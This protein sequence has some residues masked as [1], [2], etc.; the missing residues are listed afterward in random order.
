MKKVEARIYLEDIASHLCEMNVPTEYMLVEGR[1]ED[2]IIRVAQSLDKG[3]LMLSSHGQSG[4]N[5]WK[6]GS[7]AQKIILRRHAS[8]MIVRAD[9]VCESDWGSWR[10]RRL[11]VPLDGSPRAECVLPLVAVL[12]RFHE[13]VVILAHV[14]SRPELPQGLLTTCEDLELANQL[15]EHRRREGIR[16]LQ[17]MRD[18]TPADVETRLIVSDNT[19]ESLHTLIKREKIDLV[20]MSAHGYS[21][22]AEWPY[23]SLVVH[24]ITHGTTPLLI[25]QDLL[26]QAERNQGKGTLR[27]VQAELGHGR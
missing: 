26:Q 15:L 16:Y 5:D 11:L 22:K 7:V 23:G 18:H 10:Y 13:A 27:G 9:A 14:V 8:T 4:I 25:M 6:L 24:F 17:W 19:V 21:G 12:A 20:V 2:C 1:P 3:L